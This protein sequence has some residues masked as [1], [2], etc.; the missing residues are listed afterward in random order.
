MQER[1]EAVAMKG[2]P[3]TLLGPELKAGDKAPG[4]TVL[5]GDLSEVAFSPGSSQGTVLMSVPSLDTGVC[6]TEVRKFNQEID[7]LDGNVTGWAI[8]MDLPFA[9]ARWCG[10]AGVQTVKTFSDHRDADFGQKYGVLIKE[11]RL[12]A[13]SVFVVDADGVIRHVEL[14]KEVTDEPDYGA[15]LDAVRAL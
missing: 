3:L 4:F 10:A 6:D 12:L 2:N 8:S 14:V 5:D 15:A 13:R 7:K 1:K 9:Q 11:L